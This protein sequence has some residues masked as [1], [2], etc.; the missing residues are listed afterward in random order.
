[1]PT[2]LKDVN[3]DVEDGEDFIP[4]IAYTLQ[5]NGGAASGLNT[6]FLF[7]GADKPVLTPEL[8][9]VIKSLG[10]E[11][12]SEGITSPDVNKHIDDNVSPLNENVN[13][14]SQ[15]EDME[16]QEVQ[17][18]LD[19]AKQ[20]N[21]V[22][23]ARLDATEALL[24]ALEADKNARELEGFK[25][26]AVSAGVAQDQVEI[27]AKSWQAMSKVDAASVQVIIKSMKD[28]QELI[29]KSE[30]F[31]EKGHSQKTEVEQ[32]AEDALAAAIKA[33]LGL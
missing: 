25:A 20:E 7:K 23:K 26:E 30:L 8:L 11:I 31:V 3:F 6:A 15:G 32:Q 12:P 22:L 18:A 16:L 10:L 14:S 13:K 33:N 17:K 28:K 24:K 5:E 27:V 21:D 4:H 1:M 2:Y 29:S 19:S 9:E